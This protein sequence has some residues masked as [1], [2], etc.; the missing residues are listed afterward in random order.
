VTVSASIESAKPETAGFRGAE[1]MA[2]ALLHGAVT[3][4][5]K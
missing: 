4:R 5:A 3:I 2:V 1:V